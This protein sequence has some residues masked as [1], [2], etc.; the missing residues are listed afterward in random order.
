MTQDTLFSV[1][2]KVVI[3]TGGAGHLGRAMCEGLAARGA[4]VYC[5][6]RHSETF[7]VFDDFRK[8]HPA[9]PIVCKQVD[10]TDE[11][12]TAA[13]VAGIVEAEGRLDALIN[14][15]ASAPRGLNEDMSAAAWAAGLLGTFSHYYS[16]AKCCLPAMRRARS[17]VIINIASLW[18]IVS[19]DPRTYLDLG[20]EPPVFLPPAKAAILQLTRYLAVLN[21]T[22]GIRVNAIAPGWMPKKRGPDRPDY[23][24]QITQRIPMGRIGTPSEIL[25]AVV[26]LLSDASSYVTGQCIVIDGGYTLL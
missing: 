20:N 24:A 18:G 7:A 5:L 12:A 16:C 10:V 23:M 4:R 8:A 15:A 14:N 26:Y 9:A 11:P 6:G 25:G 22:T 13:V 1:S 19:P 21:A 3:V 2:G 17:G